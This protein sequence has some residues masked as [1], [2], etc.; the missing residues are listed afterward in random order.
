MDIIKDLF[1]NSHWSSLDEVFYSQFADSRFEPIDDLDLPPLENLGNVYNNYTSLT[2]LDTEGL[3]YQTEFGDNY[4]T[5]TVLPHTLISENV[6]LLVRDRVN[7]VEVM[8]L[9]EKLASGK[10]LFVYLY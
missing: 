10:V 3:D 4:D 2:F 1:S 8:D 5:V 9:I 6:F 7:P